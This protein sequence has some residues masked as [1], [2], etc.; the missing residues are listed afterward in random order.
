MFEG[1]EHQAPLLRRE[2]RGV[3][4]EFQPQTRA[5]WAAPPPS[6][7]QQAKQSPVASHWQQKALPHAHCGQLV[8]VPLQLT[9]PLTPASQLLS[10]A[11]QVPPA[12]P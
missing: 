7:R 2:E 8:T 9:F 6:Q 11:V 12:P 1:A 3:V 4:S 10:V 5:Q